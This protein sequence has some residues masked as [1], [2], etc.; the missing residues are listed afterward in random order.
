[1]SYTTDLIRNVAIAGHGG[2]GK[3]TLFEHFL[4][5][6]GVIPRAETV[7]SGKTIGD[8][9]PEEIERKISVHTTLA[10]VEKNGRKINFF[11]TPGSSDFIGDVILGF[12]AS[13]FALLTVDSRAG[14]QIETVKLWR[15]LEE[16]QKPRGVFVTKLDEERAGFDK[17][18]EDLKEKFKVD[19]VP[20]TLPMGTGANY[21]GVIDVLNSKA[22]TTSAAGELEKEGAIP[23]EYQDA[24]NA[25]R[26]RL[27]EAAAEGDDSL[28][29]KY[30][31][32]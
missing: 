1:M 20:F 26:E 11:D 29:E 23:A 16:R 15:S 19:P 4:F 31:D 32:K 8:F 22:S 7:E 27:I 13:E 21:K 14:V 9:T 28:M 10:H 2:T 25:A 18:L 17:V 5:A 30:I 24:A 12:R 6:G 3:T